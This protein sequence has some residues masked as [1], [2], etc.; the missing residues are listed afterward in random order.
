MLS[1]ALVL[2][3]LIA[4]VATAAEV[5]KAATL[6]EEHCLKCHNVS[7]RMSGLSLVS[8]ADATKGRTARAG[9]C[10]RQAGREPARADDLRRKAEDADAGGA[11]FRRARWR[12]S[13]SGSRRARPGPR[14]CAPAAS[15]KRCGRS[16]RS[17]S[18][19]SR[20]VESNWAR[21]PIDAFVLAKLKAKKL[22]PSP[23]ADRATLIRRLTYDLHGLPPTWEEVQA[24]V[25]D[26]SPDAY[27]KLV[28]R[29]LAS[30][31]YGERWGRH[32]LD[33]AHY[34]ES[35]GYDKDKP[36][37]NAWPYRDYVIRAF[38][39]DKP[40]ARFVEEQLAG[41]VLWPDDPQGG[42]RRSASSPRA[43]GISSARWSCGKAPP[44][45]TSRACSIATTW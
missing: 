3:L 14:T 6:L 30:P 7:V 43:R 34:G 39:Q 33:V 16:S 38:N 36:R 24:F 44:T 10:A 32:W 11:A 28:D 40:Y 45:R 29:L 17:R 19:R 26:R 2:S 42:C 37:R 9:D 1:R 27:E 15:R 4:S 22:T 23:E 31:R 21:T 12:R 41:D 8:L 35:H 20:S 13:G 5:P 25:A 18:R